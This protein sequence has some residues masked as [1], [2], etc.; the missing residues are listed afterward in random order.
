MIKKENI[1]K[2]KAVLLVIWLIETGKQSNLN[3]KF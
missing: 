3:E 1:L 2:I